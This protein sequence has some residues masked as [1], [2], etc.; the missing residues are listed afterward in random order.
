VLLLDTNVLGFDALEP[1]RA[2]SADY[3]VTDPAGRIIAATANVTGVPLVTADRR[4]LSMR[5]LDTIW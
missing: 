5:G 1:A 4:L 3:T 2:Q